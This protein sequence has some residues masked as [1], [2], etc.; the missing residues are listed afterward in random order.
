[1]MVLWNNTRHTK[2]AELSCLKWITLN[3]HVKCE[4]YVFITFVRNTSVVV[5]YS[6]RKFQC[7]LKDIMKLAGGALQ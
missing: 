5:D 4:I 6:R 2:M 7:E 3:R 1:M